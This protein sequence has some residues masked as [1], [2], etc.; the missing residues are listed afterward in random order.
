VGN[1]KKSIPISSQIL[2]AINWPVVVLDSTRRICQMNVS[3]QRMFSVIMNKSKD[4]IGFP[5]LSNA[6]KQIFTT[7]KRIS[8]PKK[9]KTFE[10][11]KIFQVELVRIEDTKHNPIGAI[12]TF[13]DLVCGQETGISGCYFRDL[14]TRSSNIY[15]IIEFQT[16]M[17]LDMNS[18]SSRLLGYTQ[19]ELYA[20]SFWDIE[21]EASVLRRRKIFLQAIRSRGN[22]EVDG[23]YKRKDGMTFAVRLHIFY[24][25][26]EEKEYA[27]ILAYDITHH[28]EM[29][30]KLQQQILFLQYAID[31][32]PYPVFFKDT[33]LRYLGCNTAFENMFNITRE[34][35]IGKT[36]HSII[37]KELADIIDQTDKILFKKKQVQIYKSQFVDH[38]G[39][40]KDVIFQ[41]NPFFK[42]DGTL[43]G[44][45][46][47]VINVEEFRQ[48]D[49]EL[50]SIQS[51]LE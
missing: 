19:K 30:E 14:I 10:G 47:I 41:R 3:S 43:G 26:Q 36:V 2:E 37:P 49:K 27:I 40:C 32:I 24:I 15:F 17:I 28:K 16:G 7:H 21:I 13:R 18:V 45:I 51:V 4:D 11:S 23:C 8:F 39:I 38:Q 22:W 33:Q 9:L 50:K 48:L 12:I 6:V 34:H 5:G 42:S 20:K 1:S 31:V 35:L 44:L 46:G 29:E 25:K